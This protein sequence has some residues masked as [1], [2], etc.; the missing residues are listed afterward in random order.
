[1]FKARMYLILIS[2]KTLLIYVA[3]LQSF[4]GLYDP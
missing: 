3:K 1:M 2:I 4:H